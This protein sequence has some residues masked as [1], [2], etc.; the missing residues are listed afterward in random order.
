V[1]IRPRAGEADESECKI[2]GNETEQSV[3]RRKSVAG[4]QE[5]LP[6]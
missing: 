3:S 2:G 5:L 4:V 1:T 6:A